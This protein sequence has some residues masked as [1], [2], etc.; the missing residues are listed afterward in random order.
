MKFLRSPVLSNLQY[1]SA[2]FVRTSEVVVG[3]K[4]RCEL[5]QSVNL[6]EVSSAFILC[7]VPL[8][9]SYERPNSILIAVGSNPGLVL[10]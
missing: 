10:E 5:L 4:L 1:F 8:A 7:A 3:S 6:S 2:L 9:Y